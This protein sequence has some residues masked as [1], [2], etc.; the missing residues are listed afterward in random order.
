[1]ICVYSSFYHTPPPPPPLHVHP[2]SQSPLPQVDEVENCAKLQSVVMALII[3]KK[4]RRHWVSIHVESDFVQSVVKK[5]DRMAKWAENADLHVISKKYVK[6]LE[7]LMEWLT[8]EWNFG[9]FGCI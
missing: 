7:H 2:L 5:G 4:Y 3:A 8:V 1:M 6:R 9:T